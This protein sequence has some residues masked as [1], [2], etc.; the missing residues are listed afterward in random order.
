MFIVAKTQTNDVLEIS[1]FLLI[2]F[3]A[4]LKSFIVRR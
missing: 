3:F 1:K 4:F 2:S